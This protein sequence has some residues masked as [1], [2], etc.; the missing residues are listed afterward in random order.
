MGEINAL[1]YALIACLRSLTL[2]K[3]NTVET[4][5]NDNHKKSL[6]SISSALANDLRIFESHHYFT[7]RCVRVET[8]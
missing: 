5:E 2:Q 3:K 6:E 7:T 4:T 1:R 8:S